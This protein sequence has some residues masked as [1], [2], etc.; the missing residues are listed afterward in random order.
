MLPPS[1]GDPEDISREAFEAE[2]VLHDGDMGDALMGIPVCEPS[3]PKAFGSKGDS[4]GEG[5]GIAEAVEELG[6]H[7]TLDGGPVGL[8]EVAGWGTV[9]HGFGVD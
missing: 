8:A 3:A 6:F 7:G 4:I 9:E 2:V 1:Q 5:S